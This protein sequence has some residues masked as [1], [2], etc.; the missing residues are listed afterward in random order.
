[1]PHSEQTTAV[2]TASEP[3]NE[4]KLIVERDGVFRVIVRADAAARRWGAA[5]GDHWFDAITDTEDPMSLYEHI[6]YADAVYALGK[7]LA[8]FR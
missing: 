1:M 5:E 2:L 7:K 3:P 6:K 8:D 4:T